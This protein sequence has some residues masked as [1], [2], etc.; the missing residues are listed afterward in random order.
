MEFSDVTTERLSLRLINEDDADFMLRLINSPDWIKYIGDRKVYTIESAREYIRRII[1]TPKFYYWLIKEVR[2]NLPMGII[3]FIKRDYLPNYDIGFALL[4]EFHN[5]G[6]GSEA[7]RC[8]LAYYIDEGFAP[9]LATVLPSNER[10]ILLLKKLGFIFQKDIDY[11]GERLH[12]YTSAF[13]PLD[14]S[15]S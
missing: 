7:T 4:P 5:Q 13:T 11:N 8:M 9:I 2:T 15:T 1:T 14:D 3:S 6:F 10:S 12:V